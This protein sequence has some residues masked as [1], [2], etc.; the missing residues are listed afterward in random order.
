MNYKYVYLG[1]IKDGK[2]E[3]HKVEF[4]EFF[5]NPPGLQDFTETLQAS[6]RDT[7]VDDKTYKTVTYIASISKDDVKRVLVDNKCLN[8]LYSAFRIFYYKFLKRK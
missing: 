8:F 7:V 6:I 3:I 1:F 2:Q 4:G 5:P